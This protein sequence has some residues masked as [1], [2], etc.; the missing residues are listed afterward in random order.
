DRVIGY[1]IANQ[2]EMDDAALLVFTFNGNPSFMEHRDGH[3]G[4][5]SWKDERSFSLPNLTEFGPAPTHF[6]AIFRG[7]SRRFARLSTARRRRYGGRAPLPTTPDRDDAAA[8]S[9]RSHRTRESPGMASLRAGKLFQARPVRH[10]FNVRT[11]SCA[12]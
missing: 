5:T 8:N 2:V 4:S 6:S 3:P 12:A 7:R 1:E 10:H 11:R 9:A